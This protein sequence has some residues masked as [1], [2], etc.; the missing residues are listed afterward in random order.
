M[1]SRNLELILSYIAWASGKRGVGGER[2]GILKLG[3]RLRSRKDRTRSKADLLW[4][5]MV[6]GL[7]RD[8]VAMTLA[9]L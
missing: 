4:A 2:E 5:E 9:K 1:A 3:R 8:L 7:H 6:Q